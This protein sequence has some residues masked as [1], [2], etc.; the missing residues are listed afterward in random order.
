[1]ADEGFGWWSALRWVWAN[2]AEIL[3]QLARV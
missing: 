1:M 3:G 2:E